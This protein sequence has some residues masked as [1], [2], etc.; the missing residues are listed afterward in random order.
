MQPRWPGLYMH[1]IF[2]DH[3]HAT[4][5]DRFALEYPLTPAGV[6]PKAVSYDSTWQPTPTY[7]PL[8]D[9]LPFDHMQRG[10]VRAVSGVMSDLRS[11]RLYVASLRDATLLSA[12]GENGLQGLLT[13]LNESLSSLQ[14]RCRRGRF[15]LPV[16]SQLITEVYNHRPVC[17]GGLWLSATPPY[18]S[19]GPQ[20]TATLIICVWSWDK[21]CYWVLRARLIQMMDRLLDLLRYVRTYTTSH[22][23]TDNCPEIGQYVRTLSRYTYLRL[24]RYLSAILL[25]DADFFKRVGRSPMHAMA[26]KDMSERLRL[27][28]QPLVYRLEASWSKYRLLYIDHYCFSAAYHPWAEKCIVAHPFSKELLR[29]DVAP[30]ALWPLLWVDCSKLKDHN[31]C[32]IKR[33]SWPPKLRLRKVLRVL[34]LKREAVDVFQYYLK[35]EP[36][37]LDSFTA[38]YKL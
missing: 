2:V 6:H 38:L 13:A 35:Y 22:Y 10:L 11:I 15:S 8:R 25:W 1:D 31:I 7:V 9:A 33:Q 23:M 24:P 19:H 20:Q 12:R 5:V 29:E 28:N 37:N 14:Y 34:D 30:I 17:G 36:E 21:W 32:A 27:L 16:I 18:G 3:K 4:I 26:H